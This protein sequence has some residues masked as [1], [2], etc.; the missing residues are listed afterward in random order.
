MIR[1]I[2]W[3]LGILAV[4]LVFQTTL[5]SYV[6]FF[7]VKA[8]VMLIVFVV[9][10][11]QNGSF[12]SQIV[13]FVLGF[14]LDAVTVSPLGYHTFLFSLAG[15]LFGLGSGKVYFDPLVM[16]ALLGLLA[17]LYITVGGLLVN[18][19]FRLG[20]PLSAYV[21]MGL[22]VQLVLNV[23]LAPLVFWLYGWLKEKFQDPRRGF[24]G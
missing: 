4:L 5:L 21:H 23:L 20:Q 7:G 14:A 9:L 19:V 17:T 13:G 11:I 16:P 8:D 1:T 10:A 18:T 12:A 24:G 6:V 15:Y 3:A 22:V 2:L